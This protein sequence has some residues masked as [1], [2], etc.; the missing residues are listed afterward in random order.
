MSLMFSSSVIYHLLCFTDLLNIKNSSS[1]KE[2]YLTLPVYVKYV[3]KAEMM[4]KGLRKVCS[5]H[6][7][8]SHDIKEKYSCDW[9]DSQF[10]MDSCD[11]CQPSVFV[12]ELTTGAS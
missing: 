9:D 11:S 5:S 7:V 6:P 3:K 4:A 2:T 10:M 12:K 1:F 8:N